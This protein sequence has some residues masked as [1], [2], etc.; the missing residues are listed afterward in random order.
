[1][2]SNK[3]ED[4][5]LLSSSRLQVTADRSPRCLRLG[6][7]AADPMCVQEYGASMRRKPVLVFVPG[8]P[9]PVLPAGLTE[10]EEDELLDQMMSRLIA[11]R[12]HDAPGSTMYVQV[13]VV[14][15]DRLGHNDEVIPL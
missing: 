9:R 12:C 8:Y 4:C 2:P 3:S 6:A 7:R 5:A 15:D 10:A 11:G 1:L 13:R 14:A